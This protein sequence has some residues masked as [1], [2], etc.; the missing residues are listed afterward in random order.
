M[1]HQARFE[2][3]WIVLTL[4]LLG[5]V[6]APS[7]AAEWRPYAVPAGELSADSAAVY[8]RCF[9]RVPDSMT[10]R[11]PV[12]LWS[13]SAMLSLADLAGPFAI[14]LNGTKI[15]EREVTAGRSRRRFKIPKGIFEKR[16]F[17]VSR[18]GSMA[19][20]R[21]NGLR[22]VPIL[23]RLSRR[24]RARRERGK[25]N[26]DEPAAKELKA[27]DAQPASAWFSPRRDFERLRRRSEQ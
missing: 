27:A 4:L 3:L 23:A 21:K 12:D 11:A 1:T 13:D 6:V 10:S 25:F 18:Y 14:F 26:A 15:G 9:I 16:A 17:N 8:C 5:S 19:M 7:D 24:T 2:N 20:R 22:T